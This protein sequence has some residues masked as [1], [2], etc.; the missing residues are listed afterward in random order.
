MPRASNESTACRKL[1]HIYHVAFNIPQLT[2]AER[3]GRGDGVLELMSPFIETCTIAGIVP[4]WEEACPPEF[5]LQWGDSW[6]SVRD[7]MQ[8]LA[9][10]TSATKIA[11]FDWDRG[12][13][14]PVL[15]WARKAKVI[16]CFDS[17]VRAELDYVN[18]QL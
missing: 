10:I 11:T 8:C 1:A 18:S 15:T 2:K 13:I 17:P 12:G 3:V 16:G 5:T 14:M 9:G 7:R 4:F 6:H